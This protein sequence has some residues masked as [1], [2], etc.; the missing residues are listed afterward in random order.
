MAKG[1]LT[2]VALATLSGSCSSTELGVSGQKAVPRVK[3]T[4]GTSA[5]PRD[6]RQ[7]HSRPSTPDRQYSKRK[8]RLHF[9]MSSMHPKTI[10]CWI[11]S[12]PAGLASS[13]QTQPLSVTAASLGWSNCKNSMSAHCWCCLN[14][15]LA[16]QTTELVRAVKLWG[17]RKSAP[18]LMREATK[19]P[20]VVASWNR[21]LSAPRMEGGAISEM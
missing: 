10:G 4:A 9:H 2:S 19:M 8:K 18:Q 12:E 7:P 16:V 3:M 14:Q 5:R 1:G 21:M 15:G 11:Y 20:M 17:E 6:R 13:Q